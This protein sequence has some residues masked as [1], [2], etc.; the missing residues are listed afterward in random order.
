MQRL[1]TRR[2]GGKW[3]DTQVRSGD[4]SRYRLWRDCSQVKALLKQKAQHTQGAVC[5]EGANKTEEVKVAGRPACV[6]YPSTIACCGEYGR[7]RRHS[8]GEERYG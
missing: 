4:E 2:S 3:N 1:V 8:R 6:S 7:E 5:K